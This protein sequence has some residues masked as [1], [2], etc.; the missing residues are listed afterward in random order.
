MFHLTLTFG[1]IWISFGGDVVV[2]FYCHSENRY[3][4]IGIGCS[5]VI[6]KTDSV[7][8]WCNKCKQQKFLKPY[9][10]IR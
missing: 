1:S 2:D 8:S 3:F 7:A 6:S 10:C 5:E 9:N 4:L